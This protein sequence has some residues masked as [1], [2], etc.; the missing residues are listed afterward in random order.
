MEK[1]NKELQM[2][3]EYCKKTFND[4]R[5]AIDHICEKKRRWLQRK[6][7]DSIVGFDAWGKF[8]EGLSCKDRTYKG[9]MNSKLYPSF[10]RFGR[11]MMDLNAIAPTEYVDYLLKHNF[12]LTDWTK[13]K[14]YE[15]FIRH[16]IAKESPDRGVERGILL[17]EKW[18]EDNQKAMTDF[19]SDVNTNEAVYWIAT[20]RLSPWFIYASSK[21]TEFMGRLTNE[22]ISIINNYIDNARWKAK[23]MRFKV[24]FNNLQEILEE[25]GI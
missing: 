14:P 20:G 17:A 24:E 18:A 8:M 11:H 22:Q 7:R 16:K 19:F 12:K 15:S 6:D 21:S 25:S 5:R 2:K 4:E 13:D 1:G 23:I 10:V 9:F 3:C